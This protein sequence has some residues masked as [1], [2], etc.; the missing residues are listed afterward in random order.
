MSAGPRPLSGRHALVTAMRP[1]RP[2]ATTLARPAHRCRWG[3]APAPRIK[4]PCLGAYQ[5]R[6]SSIDGSA[7]IGGVRGR[8]RQVARSTSC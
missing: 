5:L 7:A 6:M 2:P 1:D 8:A 4:W 3:T